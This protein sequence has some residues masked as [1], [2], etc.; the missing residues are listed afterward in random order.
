MRLL[1]Q[2]NSPCC[3]VYSTAFLDAVGFTLDNM[4]TIPW[5]YSL[6]LPTSSLT[7]G[8]KPWAGTVGPVQITQASLSPIEHL[9]K[10]VI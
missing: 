9:H 5:F 3:F 2:K 1:A 8:S 7:S 10:G 6:L 4:H